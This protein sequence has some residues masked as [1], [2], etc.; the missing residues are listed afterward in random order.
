MFIK[1]LT[2]PLRS[3]GTAGKTILKTCLKL[4]PEQYVKWASVTK[5][6]NPIHDVSKFDPATSKVLV[7]G[8]LNLSWFSQ[9]IAE[10][11]PGF[12]F[13]E[14]DMKFTA[15]IYFHEDVIFS[16]Q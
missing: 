16:T 9:M 13:K 7:P 15:P 14:T 11:Y 6:Y 3:F 12:S 4:T 10:A 5:D 2:V 1:S 8:K